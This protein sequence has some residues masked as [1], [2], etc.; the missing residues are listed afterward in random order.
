MFINEPIIDNKIHND[1]AYKKKNRNRLS[2][3]FWSILYPW[4]KYRRRRIYQYNDG[5]FI[6][7]S[8]QDV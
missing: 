8:Y 3:V 7:D 4:V 1:I 5:D 6:F 2:T